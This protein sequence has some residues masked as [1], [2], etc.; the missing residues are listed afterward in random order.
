M[1][2]HASID[3][4]LLLC[5]SDFKQKRI[6]TVLNYAEQLPQ[7]LAIPDQIKQV[8]LNLLNN[9]VDACVPNGGEIIVN[10][11]Q[12]E[13]II[14]IAIQDTGVGINPENLDLIFQPFYTTKPEIKGTG[15]GLSVCYGIVQAHQG[16]ISVESCP[17]KGSTFTISLPTI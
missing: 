3:Y 15:L 13:Q 7:I 14:A 5:R 6:I 4:V 17:G 11:W 10:T 9:A 1:D 12:E 16:E 8:I 2:V